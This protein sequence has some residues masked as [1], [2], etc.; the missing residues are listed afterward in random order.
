ME[1][2]NKLDHGKPPLELLD[3]QFLEGVAAVFGFGAEKYGRYNWKKGLKV[4]RLIGSLLRHAMAFA[5]GEDVDPESGHSHLYH[6]GCN[7]Q[8]LSWMIEHMEELDDRENKQIASY[9]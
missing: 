5:D 3:R 2:G 1:N 9:F 6:I 4:S 8:M 7:A